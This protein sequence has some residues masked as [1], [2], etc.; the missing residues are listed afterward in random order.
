MAYT[1]P[2]EYAG[3]TGEEWEEL[4]NVRQIESLL[5]LFIKEHVPEM[6]QRGLNPHPKVRHYG[7]GFEILFYGWAIYFENGKLWWEDTS[8]G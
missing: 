7:D 2:W 6:V 5:G 3:I 8:G 1:M 4:D